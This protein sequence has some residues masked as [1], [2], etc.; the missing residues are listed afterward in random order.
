MNL[1]EGLVAAQNMIASAND[2]PNVQKVVVVFTTKDE[3]C[4]YQQQTMKKL[5]VKLTAADNNPCAVASRIIESGSILLTVGMKFDGAL[6][7]PQL[8]LG[9][10][11]FKLNFDEY[12]SYDFLNA[13]CKA[14]CYCLQPYVQY[15]RDE[16]CVEYGEC[17]YV[18][19]GS[20]S[21][22]VA[23]DTCLDYQGTLVDVFSADKEAFITEIQ[24]PHLVSGSWL[25][26][27]ATNG[28]YQWNG[29][30]ITPNDYT[31]WAPS[32][33]QMTNGNCVAFEPKRGWISKSCDDLFETSHFVCQKK[34]CDTLH[35]CDFKTFAAVKAKNNA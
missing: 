35:Y 20:M 31:N 5:E 19:Q 25:A 16:T 13:M 26:L 15:K 4:S 3:L 2:R 8:N 33:P 14:N 30:N 10:Q 17:L 23:K 6:Y 1:K 9:S 34:S 7:F 28:V 32:Q 29:E 21:H 11:C 27:E 12:F 18:H 22:D 24:T